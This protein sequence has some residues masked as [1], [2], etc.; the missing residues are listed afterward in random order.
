M[1]ASRY[2]EAMKALRDS[3]IWLGAKQRDGL[4]F[5]PCV[6][7]CPQNRDAALT[8]RVYMAGSHS[9]ESRKQT[10]FFHLFLLVFFFPV[11]HPTASKRPTPPP[12]HP[13]RLRRGGDTMGQT[14]C[15][16]AAGS[17]KSGRGFPQP[18]LAALRSVRQRCRAAWRGNKGL[19]VKGASR[20]LG[21]EKQG[22]T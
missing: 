19:A 22:V 4:P 8:Q 3:R 6:L 17:S 15:P 2:L 20:G 18:R 13:S 21:E 16:W 7:L 5:N 11:S 12:R 10:S 14:T 1:Q 9:E